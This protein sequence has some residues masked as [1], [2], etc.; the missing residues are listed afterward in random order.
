VRRLLDAKAAP[1]IAPSRGVHL[2]VDR[3]FLAGDHAIMV[4]H[5]SDGRVMFAVPWHHVV[6]LGTT[7]TPV[8]SAELEPKASSEEIDFILE[9]ADRYLERRPSRSDIRSVFAGVRPLVKLG[10]AHSTAALSRDHTIHIDPDSGL[11]TIAGGKWT[12]YRRMAQDLVDHAETLGGLEDRPCV[13]TTLNVHGWREPA[14]TG[15]WSGPEESGPLA[16]YGAD[17]PHLAEL[18]KRDAALAKQIHPRLDVLFAQVA[19]AVRE[20]M[21]R[22]VEDVLARRTRCLLFDAQASIE[23]APGVAA[24]MAKELGRDAAW[25]AAQVKSYESLARGYLVGAK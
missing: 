21:A 20:E 25:A 2:V 11:V 9:T 12:T 23:A 19:W 16:V 8:E 14:G 10:D 15:G 7:D 13:T 3:S 1:M 18:A 17:A 4:P 5:T 24:L 6:V 22:T